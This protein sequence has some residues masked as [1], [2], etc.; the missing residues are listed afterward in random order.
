MFFEGYLFDIIIFYFFFQFFFYYIFFHIYIKLIF[1]WVEYMFFSNKFIWSKKKY[2]FFPAHH[3][4]LIGFRTCLA[5]T[6]HGTG[7]WIVYLQHC[8]QYSML[9]TWR[10]NPMPAPHMDINFHHCIV[11]ATPENHLHKNPTV[12]MGEMGN[13]TTSVPLKRKNPSQAGPIIGF[14]KNCNC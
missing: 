7:K 5:A 1:F 6:L 14:N 13:P 3:M 10:S 4:D 9:F 8:A 11:L 12:K 2:F